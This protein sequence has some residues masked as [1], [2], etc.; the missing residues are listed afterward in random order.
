MSSSIHTCQNGVRCWES[1]I[2]PC[3]LERCRLQVNRHEPLLEVIFKSLLQRKDIRSYVNAGVGWGYCLLLARRLRADIHIVGVDGDE[4]MI[5]ATKDNFLLNDVSDIK[6][7]Q[8]WLG[9]AGRKDAGSLDDLIQHKH[10]AA[11]C[12]L[13]AD[14]RGVAAMLEESPRTRNR[15]SEML[16][17]TQDGEHWECLDLLKKDG[18][19]MIRLAVEPEQMP[20]RPDGLIWATRIPR[21]ESFP[22]PEKPAV[23]QSAADW[24]E[25]ASKSPCLFSV[26]GTQYFLAHNPFGS[27]CIPS[28]YNSQSEAKAIIQGNAW[29]QET[30]EF[31][32]QHAGEGDVVHAGTHFGDMLPG[33][34]SACGDKSVVWAFEPNEISFQAA[35]MTVQINQAANV[36][37]TRA[38]LGECE[39]VADMLVRNACGHNLGG[40]SRIEPARRH[41]RQMTDRVRVTSL[42]QIIP[43]HRRVSV[44]HL[45]VEGYEHQALKGA[46]ALI[47]R[48]RPL[49]VIE[50]VP[51]Q[52]WF[53]QISLEDL[54]YRMLR[55]VDGNTVFGLQASIKSAAHG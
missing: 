36:I 34:S 43:S 33:L 12:L 23:T 22:W 39:S 16:I 1:T 6:L 55:K 49:L 24:M 51:K 50:K 10:L 18:H 52:P 42:D 13:S 25:T 35:R 54:G 46:L 19:W 17:A 11:A 3:A 32:R 29:E 7:I 4:N 28:V 37:L 44:I 31:L 8:S 9:R 45:D 47:R 5:R 48:D 27:Y 53:E 41:P 2:H 21:C 38:A 14:I 20:L 15:I 40:T 26:N 30:L